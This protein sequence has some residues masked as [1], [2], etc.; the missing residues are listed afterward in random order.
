[1]WIWVWVIAIMIVLLVA[2]KFK[3]IRH[4]FGLIIIALI[5]IF[6][7][8]SFTQIYKT[9]KP[10]LKTADGVMKV[11]KL[12]FSWLGSLIKNTGKITTYAVNQ[13]WGLN[14]T[15]STS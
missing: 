5:L 8:F 1:M 15:N 12:Y 3:E 9:N 7:I 14:A 11:G 10:D 2:F 13:N 4:K 6:L